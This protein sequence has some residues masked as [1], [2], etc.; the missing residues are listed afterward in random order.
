MSEKLT[1]IRTSSFLIHKTGTLEEV[2]QF[3]F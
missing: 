1:K 3:I 2:F